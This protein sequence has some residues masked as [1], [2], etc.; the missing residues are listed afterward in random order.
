MPERALIVDGVDLSDLGLTVRSGMAGV[1]GTPRASYPSRR[2]PGRID[3][4]PMSTQPEYQ[5]RQITVPAS[6]VGTDMADMHEKLRAV[7]AAVAPSEAE[8]TIRFVDDETVEFTGRSRGFDGQPVEPDQIQPRTDI[9]I[10][11]ECLDP[12]LL[13]VGT[14][15]PTIGST[16]T[17]MPL[18][19]QPSVPTVR[20][21][22]PFTDPVLTYSD[23][24]GATVQTLELAL[25]KAAG[26]WV[27]IDMHRK[28]IVDDA[29]ASQI[30]ALTGGDF[31]VLD[32]RDGDYD[33]DSWPQVKVSD[34]SGTVTYRKAY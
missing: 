11:F 8:R 2:V 16:L 22:G 12:R 3:A 25:S 17:D 27:E 5:N 20:I 30:S 1:R 15:T 14:E 9:A 29:G 10:S 4:V 23:D 13:A 7:A 28:T 32:P 33:T 26:A 19:T 18:G 21:D 24:G 31:F 6:V 34:G